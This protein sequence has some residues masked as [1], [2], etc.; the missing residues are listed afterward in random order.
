LIVFRS[1]ELRNIPN[2]IIL[3]EG[4]AHAV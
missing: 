3:I 1:S 4:I 2:I